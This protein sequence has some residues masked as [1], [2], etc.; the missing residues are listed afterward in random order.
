MTII[1]A[2]VLR[3]STHPFRSSALW[4]QGQRQNSR[5]AVAWCNAQEIRFFSASTTAS[6]D[7]DDND[8]PIE[9]HYHTARRLNIRNI[10]VIAHVDHGKTSLVDQLLQVSTAVSTDQQQQQ[11]TARPTRLLDSGDLEKERG[12]TITSKVTRLDY[13]EGNNTDNKTII[14]VVDT[15]GHADFTGEVDR[16]L[17]MVDGVLLV[18]DMAEGPKAQTKYV[19]NRALALGLKPLVVLNKC[20]KEDAMQKL[21]AGETETQLHELFKALGA[22]KEQMQYVT[23]YASAR[24][25]WVTMDPLEALELGEQG[26][27]NV[28]GQENPYSMKHMLK[29]VLEEIPEPLVHTFLQDSAIHDTAQEGTVFDS[30]PFSLAAVTVGYDPY[31]G[32]TCTGRI[33]SGSISVNDSVTILKRDGGETGPSGSI[34]GMFV[35]RGI[36][37]TPLEDEKAYAGDIVQVAGIPDSIAVGDTI[38]S[39]ANPVPEPIQTPPLAPPTLAMDF[40]SNNGPLAGK[41][42]SKIA[43]SQIRQRLAQE[44]DNNITLIVKASDTD[45]EKTTVY[46]RGELQLGILIET[47]RREGFEMIIS[48]PR[49]LTKICPTTNKILEPY[50]EVTVD[51][52]TEYASTVVSLLTGDRKGILISSEVMSDGKARLVMEVPS[53][54]LLGFGSE[55]A[56]ATKGSAVVNHI[57]LEDREHAGSLGTG[58]EKGK[59]VSNTLGKATTFALDNLSQRGMFVAMQCDVMAVCIMNK[60]MALLHLLLLAF[61]CYRN[62]FH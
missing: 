49:I 18:C 10:A 13:Y 32:R 33:A 51:V 31:L 15:P 44:T 11:T 26:F 59:L 45:V 23:L 25:G 34:S 53:R 12:I 54:G 6:S 41:E 58:L 30:D 7:I 36:S 1:A 35:Y 21:D 60:C 42:G 46:A 24:N 56:T 57:F 62:T 5:L 8:S 38:T 52:D 39:T 28:N 43:S 3:W 40:G 47:M 17:S 2:N 61:Y 50:E 9:A 27:A 4:R 20:D 55:I 16:I 19:L 29:C 14:N 48:P 37:R 22:T